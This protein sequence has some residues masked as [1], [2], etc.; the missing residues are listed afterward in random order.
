[1][2]FQL[3]FQNTASLLESGNTGY[4]KF[5]T[6]PKKRIPSQGPHGWVMEAHSN[7]T[8]SQ[9][10]LQSSHSTGDQALDEIKIPACGTEA[11]D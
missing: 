5:H 6:N 9:N 3:A 11:T 8:I 10:F 2:A 7:L 1:M 4:T